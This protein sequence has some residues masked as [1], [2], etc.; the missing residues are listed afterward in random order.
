MRWHLVV[1]SWW[2]AGCAFNHPRPSGAARVV[3]FSNRGLR[4]D[5]RYL[6]FRPKLDDVVA[7]LGDPTRSED[8]VYTYDDLGLVLR[9]DDDR[10]TVVRV[11]VLLR[12]S[13]DAASRF[14]GALWL[15]NRRLSAGAT[16]TTCAGILHQPLQD[17][18]VGIDVGGVG[19]SCFGDGPLVDEVMFSYPA[20]ATP[21]DPREDLDDEP[22]CPKWSMAC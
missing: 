10:K 14:Q 20:A 5:G 21:P 12:R 8:A 22:P 2:V 3:A 19:V 7:I 9:V 6:D 17:G 4:I 1:V 15:G 18:G 13:P 11:S 16:L